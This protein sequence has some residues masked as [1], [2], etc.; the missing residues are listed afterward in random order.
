[1]TYYDGILLLTVNL[2]PSNLSSGKV[3]G[4]TKYIRFFFFAANP[5]TLNHKNIDI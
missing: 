3:H 4:P 1:M 2:N 5:D